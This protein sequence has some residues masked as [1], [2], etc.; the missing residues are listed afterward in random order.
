MVSFYFFKVNNCYYEVKY[1]ALQNDAAHCVVFR[2]T[3]NCGSVVFYDVRVKSLLPL[4][5]HTRIIF[6]FPE[7]ADYYS[8]RLQSV[9]FM[10]VT[11]E[12]L[13]KISLSRISLEKVIIIDYISAQVRQH[14]FEQ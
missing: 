9:R 12:M 4:V 11:G 6:Y 14:L 8:I 7:W 5:L 3:L 2:H 1:F 13:L 10:S